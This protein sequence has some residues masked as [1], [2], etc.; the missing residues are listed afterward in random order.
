MQS[1]LDAPRY[2]SLAPADRIAMQ[3]AEDA[4][5]DAVVL[6][7]EQVRKSLPDSLKRHAPNA[8]FVGLFTGL[9]RLIAETQEPQLGMMLAQGLE[10]IITLEV[11]HWQ[12][13]AYVD[14][15]R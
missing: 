8:A 9:S 7:Y 5:H 3:M 4:A 14:V 6:L 13:G 10:K 15:H 11:A 2:Q 1:L 12:E